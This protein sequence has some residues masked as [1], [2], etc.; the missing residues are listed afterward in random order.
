MFPVERVLETE[1]KRE[2]GIGGGGFC[3]HFYGGGCGAGLR[4]NLQG[5]EGVRFIPCKYNNVFCL[6][7]I[8]PCKRKCVF[9][10][11]LNIS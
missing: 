7:F 8:V 11:R 9:Q 2:L 4:L 10:A 6:Q 3:V 5:F 1:E